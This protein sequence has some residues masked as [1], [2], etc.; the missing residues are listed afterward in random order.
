M[1]ELRTVRRARGARTEA[2][3]A[4]LMLR[5]PGPRA[6]ASLA[7]RM[8]TVI[9]SR[10]AIGTAGSRHFSLPDGASG[11]RQR[12]CFAVQDNMSAGGI[13]RPRELSVTLFI[14]AGVGQPAGIASPTCSF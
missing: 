12:V 3:Q 4:A 10:F 7:V 6:T 9:V 14:R 13:K 5:P 11:Q 8:A 2:P 1:R